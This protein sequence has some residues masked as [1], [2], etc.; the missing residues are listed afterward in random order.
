MEF[1]EVEVDKERFFEGEELCDKVHNDGD[2]WVI[3]INYVDK[4]VEEVL[5]GMYEAL[6]VK[7]MIDWY[8]W[9]GRTLMVTLTDKLM[10]I[11]FLFLELIWLIKLVNFL[12]TK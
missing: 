3:C 4:E 7:E 12:K 11:L 8:S 6:I 2:W 9:S 10:L 1:G 5:E